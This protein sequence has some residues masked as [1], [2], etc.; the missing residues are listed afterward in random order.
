MGILNYFEIFDNGLVCNY[1]NTGYDY[2]FKAIVTNEV[3]SYER[4]HNGL[5][6]THTFLR[7]VLNKEQL[8]RVIC[9]MPIGRIPHVIEIDVN[10][11]N[12]AYINNKVSD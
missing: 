11:F 1:L 3:N 4:K 10:I 5:I 2:A 9:D 7:T 12:K 8:I 6:E